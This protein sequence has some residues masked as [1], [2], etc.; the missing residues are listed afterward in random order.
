MSDDLRGAVPAGETHTRPED[1]AIVRLMLTEIALII[2]GALLGKVLFERVGA[3]GLLGMMV[4]GV[5]LG[6]SLLGFISPGLHHVLEEFETVALIVI[7]I[8]AGQGISRDTL[9][10][11]GGP[12]VRMGF[13]PGILE[14]AAVALAACV[15]LDLAP[16]EAG[17]LGFIIAAVSPA[18][19]VPQ[20]LELKERGF[21]KHKEVPTLVLAGASLDD[22][23]AITLFGVFAGL[24]SGGSTDWLAVLVGVPAGIVLGAGLGLALGAL[25]VWFFKRHHMRDTVKVILFMLIAVVFHEASEMPALKRHVPVAALLGIMAIGFV[26]LERYDVLAKRLAA[27]FNRVWVLSEVLLFVYIGA[28][29]QLHAL[30]LRLVGVGVLVLAFG[31]V[32]RS[33][34]VGLALM[35]SKLNRKERIFCM[36]AYLPKATVQAAMGAVPWTLAVREGSCRTPQLKAARRSWPWPC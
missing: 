12:A 9:K 28:E 4:A 26:I 25:L 27:K 14:G 17:M 8:R 11:I 5:V 3:P 13:V 1:R 36:L 16:Y 10:T 24:A 32:V 21:G 33:A 18:V 7:L 31:L 2:S 22:V 34:G 19:V 30:D 29:V 6:P 23:F 20:M 15:F 35:G